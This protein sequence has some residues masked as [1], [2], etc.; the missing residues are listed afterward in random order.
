MKSTPNSLKY[1]NSLYLQSH[2]KN[3]VNWF[4]WNEESLN[5]AKKEKKPIIL[6]IGYSSCHWCH[7][8]EKESFMDEKIAEI[9][10]TF[11][12]NI[13]VDREER[14]DIDKIYMESIQN[15]G[16]NGGW[17]LNIFLTPN[18]KPFYGGTYFTKN[19]W[20]NL[21][22]S[23]SDAYK[24]NRE[25][26]EKSA[27]NFTESL[28]KSEIE[29]YNLSKYDKKINK[30]Y[31]ENIVKNLKSKFDEINGGLIGAPK[32]PMPSIWEFL[33]NYS[34]FFKDKKI[35]NHI[36]L[37]L[38]QISKGGIYDQ[39]EGGFCRY[40]VDEKWKNP[41]FEKMLYDNGQLLNLYSNFYKITNDDKY[42]KVL[43]DTID[44][45][46]NEMMDSNGGF[47]SSIDADSEGEEGKYYKWNK[48][49]FIKVAGKDYKMFS[50]YYGLNIYQD[51][52]TLNRR[53]DDSSFIKKWKINKKEFFEKLD[54]F[55]FK[56][57]KK[58]NKKEKPIIDK[59][60]ISS[61]NGLALIGLLNTYEATK[62]YKLLRIAKKNIS[63]IRESMI[64][65]DKLLHT[66][67]NHT[68]GFFDDYAIIIKSLIKYHEI[69][70]EMRYL[71]ITKKLIDISI[72]K[73]YSKK[74]KFFYYTSKQS[75][76]L[77]VKKIE[78]FDNVIPSSNS[79]MAENLIK[80][81]KLFDESKYYK[82]GE[83]MLLNVIKICKYEHS[84]LSNWLNVLLNYRI[85][86]NEIILTGKNTTATIRKINLKY[87][88]NKV[89]L[90]SEKKNKMKILKGKIF[91]EKINI[92]LCKNK[93]C[94]LP[95]NNLDELNKLIKNNNVLN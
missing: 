8:M 5:K 58:R 59:K 44:W 68:E 89:I 13:K 1:E 27:I 82:I 86:F 54:N 21:L 45:L 48:N 49:E 39:L 33:I 14:P 12:I 79:I 42:K 29:K 74:E 25:E 66:Y 46:K 50:E 2:S 65:K 9:M 91:S 94:Q 60:I 81:S 90:A 87:L 85:G 64:I 62:D 35:K 56:L 7:V 22:V 71:D 31:F 19:N 41:H 32:F 52:F 92:Y 84:F 73:F 93:V 53:Y 18:Q 4:S 69:T 6:S 24:N 16:I 38:N 51:E 47:Y 43:Y 3:P 78:L 72:Q 80:I 75:N 57:I 34:F 83:N 30:N 11:F 95:V 20:K 63:F 15:M 40:S 10:N 23:V 55:K 67:N 28:K 88:T 76:K 77:I 36:S 37:T 17:P 26:I 70:Q 61:W